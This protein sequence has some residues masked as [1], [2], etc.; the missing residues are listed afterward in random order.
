MRRR[1]QN[2]PEED[3]TGISVA[4][5]D[6]N[7][8]H[9]PARVFYNRHARTFYVLTYGMGADPWFGDMVSDIDTVELYRKTSEFPDVRITADELRLMELDVV[10]YAVW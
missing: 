3:P 2:R 10:P 7:S 6:F 8:H 1:H 5:R 9:G 4:V